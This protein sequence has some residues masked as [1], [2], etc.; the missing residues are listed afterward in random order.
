[1]TLIADLEE[2]FN[3]TLETDDIVDFSSYSKGISI[4]KKYNINIS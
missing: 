4:L 3:V 1:M 2:T